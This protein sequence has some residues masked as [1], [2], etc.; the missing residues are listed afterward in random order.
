MPK[1]VEEIN[2]AELPLGEHLKI[3]HRQGSTLFVS[4]KNS[5]E[6]LTDDEKQ[7]NLQN[8]QNHPTK[9]KLSN[10]IVINSDGKPLGDISSEGIILGEQLMD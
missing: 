8:L 10:V 6:T 9:I 1:D 2:V 5:W 3:A 7:A 4:A